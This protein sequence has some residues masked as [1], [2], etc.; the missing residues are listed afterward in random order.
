MAQFQFTARDSAGNSITGI[1]AGANPA[2][3]TQQLRASGKFP[4]SIEPVTATTQ[5]KAIKTVTGIRVCRKDVITLIQQLT[6]MLE[7]G[8]TLAEAL[9]CV[10]GQTTKPNM[11]ALLSDVT[12]FVHAGNDLS[13]ALARHPRSF[14]KLFVALIAAAEKSGMMSKLMNRGVQYLRDEQETIRRVRGALTYPCIMLAFALLTTTFLLT[15][16]LPKFTV[17]YA[18]KRAALPLPTKLLIGLSNYVCTNWLTLLGAI[19][20]AVFAFLFIRSTGS[21]KRQLDRF[22]LQLPVLGSLFRTLYLSRG[23]RMIGT[24]AGAGV[25]LVECVETAR[26]LS[27]NS[28]FEDLW[29]DVSTR[30]TAGRQMSEPL[31]ASTLIPKS[32]SQ[33][34]HSA[35]RGGKLAIVAEQ[36]ATYSEQELK[37]RI[38]ELT[39]YIEPA[40][41]VVMGAIIGSVAL[42]LMLPIFT[43]SRVIA[44]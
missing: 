14:P 15:F 10:S 11:A 30:I 21:G 5:P 4:I 35:E 19:F 40:M 3:V 2:A 32:I 23:L 43:I 26:Q 31:A 7:T 17:I 41:I 44:Q 22:Q 29:S 9:D 36:V 27:G 28:C 42:A 37:E 33:M 13:A 38:A 18:S 20:A 39:R 34:I 8:V 16:V 6:I 1:M 24:M 12:Q 25:N